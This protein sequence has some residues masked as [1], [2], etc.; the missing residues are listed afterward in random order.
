M[1]ADLC[2]TSCRSCRHSPPAGTPGGCALVAGNTSA[3]LWEH[4]WPPQ[5]VLVDTRNVK[6]LTE[7]TK[8]EVGDQP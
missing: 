6:E 1:G 7:I 8:T 2:M 4:E 3:G 5:R